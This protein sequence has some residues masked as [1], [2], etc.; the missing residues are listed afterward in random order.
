M[1]AEFASAYRS[2][3]L[4]RDEKFLK[5]RWKVVTELC[6][7]LKPAGALE[8]VRI[9]LDLPSY[10]RSSVAALFDAVK[11]PGP[12]YA[13][14]EVTLELRI[15]AA[16][17][18]ARL[19]S[20]ADLCRSTVADSGSLA[21]LSARMWQPTSTLSIA[22][23]DAHPRATKHI[24]FRGVTIRQHLAPS[25]KLQPKRLELSAPNLSV[26]A[27]TLNVKAPFEFR[28]DYYGRTYKSEIQFSFTID[29]PSADAVSQWLEQ[30]QHATDR[31]QRTVHE[32]IQ[33]QFETHASLIPSFR[34]TLEEQNNILWWL[35]GES[36]NRHLQPFANISVPALCTLA[37]QELNDLVV[38]VPGPAASVSFLARALRTGRTALPDRV[39]VT[40]VAAAATGWPAPPP[41]IADFCP[42][43]RMIH[44]TAGPASDCGRFAEELPPIEMAYQ[45]FL[46]LQLRRLVEEVAQ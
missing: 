6:S 32:A 38:L 23:P 5:G 8:L 1:D 43:S 41:S 17:A 18:L 22:H 13:R 7:H 40:E 4:E 14:P 25:P 11:D 27:K 9:Y 16:F 36:S 42:V 21:L 19:F 30:L 28:D 3:T 15:L 12:Q 26:V 39:S 45:A 44:G 24:Q 31:Y 29:V 46:E 35:F 34:T 2:A 10:D 37:A 20:D 33:R